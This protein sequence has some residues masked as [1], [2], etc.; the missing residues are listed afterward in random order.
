FVCFASS[1]SAFRIS[2]KPSNPT[3]VVLGVNSSQVTLVWRYTDAPGQ[4]FV[5]FWRQK[6]G[7]KITQISTSKNGNAFDPSD[8]EEF[9]ARLP[10][11]LILKSVKASENYTYSLFLLDSNAITKDTHAVSIKV[12]VPPEI[13]I[14]PEPRPL[15]TI[16]KNYTLT[17]NAS[18]DPLPKITWTKRWNPS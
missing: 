17:C 8:T 12:V 2:Q 5:Q 16:G 18:G 11:T 6:T 15:L 3:I 4:Y 10:A 1:E 9:V 13:T 7:E 14:P